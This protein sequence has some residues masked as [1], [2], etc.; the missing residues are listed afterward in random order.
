MTIEILSGRL[1]KIPGKILE[2]A[3]RLRY[4]IYLQEGFL[5]ENND[6]IDRDEYDEKAEHFIALDSGKV[7]GYLR[8]IEEKL[9]LDAIYE[10]EKNEVIRKYGFKKSAELSRLVIQKEYRI[11]KTKINDFSFTS[12]IL[13][14]KLYEYIF[15]N[16]FDLVLAVVN[17][18]HRKRYEEF[19]FFKA[20]GEQKAYSSVNDNPAVFL[21]QDVEE[22]R[23]KM[24]VNKAF[25]EFMLK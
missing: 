12:F 6:E 16:N 13:F 18:K 2:Q 8:L 24:K 25:F 1:E 17:P 4:K 11:E 14:K 20:F 3:F 22:A 10:K 5:K 15:A 7:V 9:P 23:E 21:F 19:Y